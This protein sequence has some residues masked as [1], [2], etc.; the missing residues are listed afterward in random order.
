MLT[1]SL[2]SYIESRPDVCGGKPCIAGRRIRV[3]DVATWYEQMKM[4]IEEIAREFD[5]APQEIHAAL[6]Y[7]Y[8]HH[9]EIEARQAQDDEFIEEMKRQY[10]SQLAD[11]LAEKRR[12]DSP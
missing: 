12:Q 11:R 8:E 1:R 4:S 6:A 2:D 5:L 7:Y 9:D 10:P 3:I